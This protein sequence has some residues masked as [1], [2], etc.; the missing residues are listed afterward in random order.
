MADLVVVVDTQGDFMRADGALPVPGAEALVAPLHDWLARRTA[1]DTAAVVFTFDTHFADTYPASAEAALFPL[2]CVRDT[3]GW[4]NLI[5][6]GAVA[7]DVPCFRLE[8]GV[9]DM[10]EEADV[11]LHDTRDP[12]GPGVPRDAFFAAQ[13]SAGVAR[14]I[15]VGVAADFCVRSAI[16]GLVAR[17]FAVRVPE[18]LT[19]GIERGIERVL[20]EDFPDAPVALDRDEIRASSTTSAW[21]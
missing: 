19:A 12:D 13:R 15:V 14:A 7:A 11:V 18:A 2:H 16:A 9:F 17:G 3:P 8:K 20:A 10:W 5:D 1:A 4:H 21:S 6:A